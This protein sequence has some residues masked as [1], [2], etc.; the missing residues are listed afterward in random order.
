MCFNFPLASLIGIP[1]GVTNFARGLKIRA[2]NGEIQTYNWIMKKKKMKHDKSALL[3]KSNLNVIEGLISKTLFDAN[4]SHYGFILANNMSKEYDEMK[5]VV[6]KFKDLKIKNHFV[7]SV[8][9]IQKVKIQK[10]EGQK[11]E[12]QWFYQ[13]MQYVIVENQNLK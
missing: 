7:W 6:K 1:V 9:K 4:V 8:E 2:I 13:N 3:A 12:K 10:L 5:E 11:T